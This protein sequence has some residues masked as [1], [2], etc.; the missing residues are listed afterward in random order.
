MACLGAA[1]FPADLVQ[2]L[3]QGLLILLV[4]CLGTG[5]MEEGREEARQRLDPQL[6]LRPRTT[7]SSSHPANPPQQPL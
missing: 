7:E 1:Q 4:G 6:A 3:L 5:Q 2:A